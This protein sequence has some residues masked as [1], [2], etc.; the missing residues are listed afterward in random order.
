NRRNLLVAGSGGDPVRQGEIRRKPQRQ[1]DRL[2]LLRQSGWTRAA[3]DPGRSPE[4]RGIRGAILCRAAAGR[5]ERSAGARHG[6]ALPAR[7]RTQSS[8]RPLPLGGDQGVQ[9]RL[10][11]TVEGYGPRL[12]LGRGRYSGGR[13]LGSGGGLSHATIRRSRR[14]LSYPRRNQGDVQGAG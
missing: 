5:R 2:R 1:E 10:L 3:A 8:V 13:W 9:A 14:R 6:P 4:N 7:L 11:S 12:G